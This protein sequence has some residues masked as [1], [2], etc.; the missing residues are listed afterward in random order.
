MARS[1]TRVSR[2]TPRTKRVAQKPNELYEEYESR[3]GRIATY[4]PLIHVILESFA[5]NIW[6]IAPEFAR[7]LT[8]DLPT[9]R[10]VAKLRSTL[11]EVDIEEDVIA[12]LKDLLTRVESLN[13]Q[14]NELMHSIWIL[15][16]DKPVM[17]SRKHKSGEKTVA[18]TLQELE[19]LFSSIADLTT[20][21]WE[22]SKR[23][24]LLGAIG[25]AT[26]KKYGK[27]ASSQN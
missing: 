19:G 22:F 17:I 7:I 24:G 8:K 2:K 20:E 6:G 3:I 25:L 11:K 23:N 13:E 18:P 4:F 5:W 26:K 12:Q 14:R 21:L 1:Q 15:D 10:L 27:P 9:G 16:G